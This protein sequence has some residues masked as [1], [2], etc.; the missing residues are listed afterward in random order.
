M[1]YSIQQIKYEFLYAIKEF[2]SDGRQWRI[3]VSDLPPAETLAREGIDPQDCV[4]VGKP[5]GTPRAAQLVRDFFLD[6]YD[7][8]DVGR[9]GEG[10][11]ALSWVVLFRPKASLP[12]PAVDLTGEEEEVTGFRT[13][14]RG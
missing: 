1:L 10:G 14:C 2:D 12:R 8:P 6:R 7:V 13:R 3:A 11:S 5:A 9:S 4:F